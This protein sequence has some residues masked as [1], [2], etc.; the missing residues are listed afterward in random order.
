MQ[1]SQG[2]DLPPDKNEK[3][4]PRTD[5]S[6]GWKRAALVLASLATAPMSAYAQDGS[7]SGSVTGTGDIALPDAT[8][9]AVNTE[10]GAEVRVRSMLDGQYEIEALPV[11]CLAAQIRPLR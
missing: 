6:T 4:F 3:A 2:T 8:I 7:L 10:T 1:S 11:E 5:T 9:L